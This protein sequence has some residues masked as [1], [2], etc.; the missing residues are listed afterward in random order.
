MDVATTKFTSVEAGLQ[1]HQAGLQNLEVQI[2]NLVGILTERPKGALP[3]QT[4]AN[5]RYQAGCNAIYFR[6]GKVT[7]GVVAKEVVEKEV[8]N[9]KDGDE[10]PSKGEKEVARKTLPTP[11]PVAKYKPPLPFPTKVYK[12]RLEAE[13]GGFM[14][15][16]RNLHLNIP[17]LEAMAHMPRYAKYL[18]GF[19]TKKPKF[20]DLANVTLGEE[21]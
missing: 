12:E 10:E 9:P 19:L 4:V 13:C 7:P 2:S 15:M 18:K 8:S 21:C 16:F 1:S 14:E 17:F 20:E 11:S 5:P 3:S 6:S